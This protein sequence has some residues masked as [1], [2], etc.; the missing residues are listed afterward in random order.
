MA[1]KYKA[2]P[3]VISIH[4]EGENPIFGERA[5]HVCLQDEGGGAFIALRQSHDDIKPGEVR[6]DMDELE[7]VLRVATELINGAQCGPR[8]GNGR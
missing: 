1:L 5:T 3:L 8:R 7:F 4:Q 2:T 6:L